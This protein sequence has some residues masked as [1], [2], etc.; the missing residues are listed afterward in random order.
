MKKSVKNTMALLMLISTLTLASCWTMTHTVGQ[1]GQGGQI[2]TAKQ[3]YVLWGLVP[4][5]EVD[6]KEMAGGA[7]DYTVTTEM[8]FIDGLISA[9]LGGIS[10]GT[11]TVEVEK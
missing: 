6:S 1:G 7:S 9:V 10:I 4:I 5:S 3:W 11:R 2:E 8:T